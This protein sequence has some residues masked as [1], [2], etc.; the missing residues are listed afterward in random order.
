MIAT[1]G[2]PLPADR[3]ARIRDLELVR[4]LASRHEV[5]LAPIVPANELASLRGL[6]AEVAR[7]LPI[8]SAA[9]MARVPCRLP[10]LARGLPAACLPYLG[11]GVR[12]VFARMVEEVH[13]ASVQ[14]EHSFLSPLVDEIDAGSCRRVLSLHNVASGQY[15]S[16]ARATRGAQRG[17]VELKQ[18]LA[19][20]LERRYLPRFEAVVVV[21]RPERD[22]VLRLDPGAEVTVIENGVDTSRLQP[23]P[24]PSRRSVLFVANL[25]YG[26]NQAAVRWLCDEIVPALRQLSPRAEVRVV[27]TGGSRRL[28]RLAAQAE[29]Q[30]V[31]GVSDLLPHYGRASVCVAPL[32]AGGGSRV[33]ILEAM[34]L[35]RPVVS[36]PLGAAGLELEPDRHILLAA[37]AGGFA[38]QISRAFADQELWGRVSAE[39]RARAEARY[40][41]DML[42]ARL[43]QLHERL[44]GS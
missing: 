2:S 36:T 24:R 29:V 34:A 16:I 10:L 32:R 31:G 35:G 3:G 27:G 41:W 30:M 44:A 4:R 33:K 38:R 19:T 1:L 7:V 37:D 39:A 8:A 40:D 20:G 5:I 18:R 13:P 6:H 12:R 9:S 21:S 23:L 17:L 26:P 42:G 11:W 15:A 28:R 14:V 25:E 22:A 43:G